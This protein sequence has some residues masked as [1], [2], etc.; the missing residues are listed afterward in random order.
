MVTRRK[1]DLILV[2]L[3]E[4]LVVEH[5]CVVA[6][7]VRGAHCPAGAREGTFHLLREQVT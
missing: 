3:L 7:V 2:E 1:G 4:L 5:G 6:P